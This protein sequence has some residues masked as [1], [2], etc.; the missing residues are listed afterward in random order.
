MSYADIASYQFERGKG[1]TEESVLAFRVLTLEL[2]EQLSSGGAGNT[3]NSGTFSGP[4]SLAEVQLIIQHRTTN[5]LTERMQHPANQQPA[6]QIAQQ[7]SDDLTTTSRWL[8]LVGSEDSSTRAV[9]SPRLPV[10]S[11][12]VTPPISESGFFKILRDN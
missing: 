7:P 2:I 1:F 8:Q 4:L 10:S 12:Q 6:E 11:T 3:K 9:I 5:N